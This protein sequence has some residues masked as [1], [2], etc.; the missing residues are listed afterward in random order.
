MSRPPRTRIY[1]YSRPPARPFVRDRPPCPICIPQLVQT[2]H[3]RS[4]RARQQQDRQRCQFVWYPIRGRRIGQQDVVP[5]PQLHRGLPG[6]VRHVQKGQQ[7]VTPCS[8]H[9]VNRSD[10]LDSPRTHDRMVSH[11]TQARAIGSGDKRFVRVVY[12]QTRHNH[13]VLTLRWGGRKNVLE[14]FSFTEDKRKE[15]RD[16]IEERARLLN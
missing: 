5:R 10:T 4:T 12:R 7:C 14:S 1:L 11:G 13:R 6:H 16:N 15:V 2:G 9:P 8:V 3:W